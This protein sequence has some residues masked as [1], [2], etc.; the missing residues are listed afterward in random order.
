[1]VC[2]LHEFNYNLTVVIVAIVTLLNLIYALFILQGFQTA[3]GI[4]VGLLTCNN[5]QTF[6]T[7]K[8]TYIYT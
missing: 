5:L 8:T 6:M 7:I 3:L 1:M 2:A 4:L